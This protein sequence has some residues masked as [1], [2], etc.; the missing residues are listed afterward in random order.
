MG[1]SHRELSV[2]GM[3][4][5]VTHYD[6]SSV[7]KKDREGPFDSAVALEIVE[8]MHQAHLD[9]LIIDCAD[10]VRYRSHPELKKHYTV[11]MR[12]L[13]K[14]AASAREAGIDVVPKLN[15]AKSHRNH[16]DVW[17][18]KHCP[19][20]GWPNY[21]Q[22]YQVAEDLISELVEALRPERFFHIGMDEDHSR[23]HVQYVSTIKKLRRIVKKFNL[24]TVIWND[25]AHDNPGSIAQVH[26]EKSLAAEKLIP[27][28][29]VHMP[30][31]YGFARPSVVK[32]LV[33]EGFEVWAAP[34]GDPENVKRWR[35]ALLAHGGKGIVLTSWTKCDR[36]H[37]KRL[38]ETIRTCGPH[39]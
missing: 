11:P 15:F 28:D 26:A 36:N 32:R 21:E 20:H 37:R 34:G 4:I 23:S 9:L 1:E 24:R 7:R 13:R 14:V 3:L 25:S 5:H 27:R 22:Y 12:E 19:E 33:S 10:G 16:H 2:K 18:G 38:L 17:M 35:R 30:W 8:A 39:L 6:P 29:I 31:A